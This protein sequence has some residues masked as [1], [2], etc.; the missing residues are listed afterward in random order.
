LDSVFERADRVVVDGPSLHDSGVADF[1]HD[2]AALMKHIEG[3]RKEML[4]AAGNL[5]FEKAARLRDEMK[6]LEDAD[7][8]LL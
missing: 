5:E 8:G 4:E 6:K 2:P 3:L 7:L 1:A